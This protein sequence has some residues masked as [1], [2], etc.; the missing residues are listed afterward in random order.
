M[1]AFTLDEWTDTCTRVFMHESDP[2]LHMW[3][4][5]YVRP[6]KTLDPT[7]A[8]VLY[9]KYMLALLRAQPPIFNE[10]YDFTLLYFLRELHIPVTFEMLW[11]AS[12]PH[13]QYH[14]IHSLVQYGAGKY[15]NECYEGIP[16][17]MR[18][19]RMEDGR[20]LPMMLENNLNVFVVDSNGYSPLHEAMYRLHVETIRRLVSYIRTEEQAN[21][22]GGSTNAKKM[23]PLHVWTT[24]PHPASREVCM[25]CISYIPEDMRALWMN[26]VDARGWIPLQCSLYSED[27]GFFYAC[28]QLH[29]LVPHWTKCV[30]PIYQDTLLHLLA[31]RKTWDKDDMLE[32]LFLLPKKARVRMHEQANLHGVTPWLACVASGQVLS[33]RTM[34]TL[35]VKDVSDSRDSSAH[36]I[37]T[38]VLNDRDANGNTAL[39]V[40]MIHLPEAE[41]DVEERFIQIQTAL[42]LLVHEYKIYEVLR[43]LAGHES[44]LENKRGRTPRYLWEK[45]IRK[46]P[47]VEHTRYSHFLEFLR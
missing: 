19:C 47:Q 27:V 1:S 9:P 6:L 12:V 15:L 40:L 42:S 30:D 23:N 4:S 3:V 41:E 32:Y 26:Q 7:Y 31:W 18:A 14:V 46:H 5:T 43:P 37:Q 13:A 25:A 24:S 11:V 16:Y 28:V 10:V 29:Y 8:K 34:M 2:D 38:M 39:H 20:V 45:W 44:P 33:I 21:I 22:L 17:A 35:R 36:A